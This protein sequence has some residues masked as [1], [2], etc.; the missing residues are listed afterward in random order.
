M[1][2][3]T[4]HLYE[5]TVAAS[6]L[7]IDLESNMNPGATPEQIE[8]E[9]KELQFELPSEVLDLY[10]WKNGARLEGQ[11]RDFRMFP[12]FYFLPLQRSIE[13]TRI[14]ISTVGKTHSQWQ[15]SW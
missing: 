14:L 8:N 9:T 12:R 15:K 3:I 11:R 2:E 4:K 13:T 1:S 7:G 10:R 5:I 6:R